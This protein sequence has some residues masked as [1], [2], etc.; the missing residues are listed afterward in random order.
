MKFIQNIKNINV[1]TKSNIYSNSKFKINI[2]NNLI[3]FLEKWLSKEYYKDVDKI[4][5]MSRIFNEYK[6]TYNL[7][8]DYD[9]EIINFTLL[10]I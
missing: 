7:L 3:K 8:K 6:L 4:S 2:S 1:Y 5:K 9:K 10:N